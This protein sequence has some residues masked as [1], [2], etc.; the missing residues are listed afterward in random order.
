MDIVKMEMHSG[1]FEYEPKFKNKDFNQE[2][3]RDE[4]SPGFSSEWTNIRV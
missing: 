1:I 3:N 2:E 4:V